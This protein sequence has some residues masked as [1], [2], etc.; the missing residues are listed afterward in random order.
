MY[1]SRAGELVIE[2]ELRTQLQQTQGSRLCTVFDRQNKISTAVSHI[3][4]TLYVIVS[5]AQI[6]FIKGQIISKRLLVSSDS[7]K[8][9][10][11]EFG[12][13]A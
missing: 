6:Q 4:S 11:N 8:K 5:A 1:V 2:L 3:V 10:I 9:R 12:F 13:F 7:S